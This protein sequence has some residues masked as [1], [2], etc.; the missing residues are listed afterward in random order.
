M[1]EGIIPGT[2]SVVESDGAQRIDI[3]LLSPFLKDSGL[4][5]VDSTFTH[6]IEP[7]RPIAFNSEEIVFNFPNTATAFTDLKN[8]EIYICGELVTKSW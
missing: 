1:S 7:D 3:R 6:S 4:I 2:S 8:T 5:G